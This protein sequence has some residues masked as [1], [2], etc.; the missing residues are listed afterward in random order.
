MLFLLYKTSKDE[1]VFLVYL[2]GSLHFLIVRISLI[3]AR[4]EWSIEY[5]HVTKTR[6][7]HS[8][9][10]LIKSGKIPGN[11]IEVNSN[12]LSSFMLR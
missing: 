5:A 8:G 1:G 10:L 4:E 12:L 7:L 9:H 2:F 6:Y 3:R 11:I